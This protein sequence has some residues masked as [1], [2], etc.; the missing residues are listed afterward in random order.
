MLTSSH[1]NYAGLT[2]QH[3]STSVQNVP[4]SYRIY[5]A[6]FSATTNKMAFKLINF[7][8]GRC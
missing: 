4:I 5:F 8:D 2:A 1:K 7:T 3:L 6:Y